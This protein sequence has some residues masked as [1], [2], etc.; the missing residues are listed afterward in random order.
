MTEYTYNGN[1][2]IETSENVYQLINAPIS[3]KIGGFLRTL[4]Y[5]WIFS[6]IPLGIYHGLDYYLDFEVSWLRYAQFVI[7]ALV[8]WV[9]IGGLF[10][11]KITRCPYCDGEMGRNTNINLTNRDKEVIQCER[12]YE[13]LIIDDGTMRAFT[14]DDAQPNQQFEAPVFENSVWP[15]ECIACGDPVTHYEEL[16]AER[17]NGELLVLGL[18]ST[19]SGSISNIPY[20]DKHNKVVSL[21]IKSDG[22]L[23]VSFPDFEMFKRF[24]TIN[25]VRKI[26]II[27]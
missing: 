13:Q 2:K 18:A 17:F 11:D 4:L 27:K 20:C 12:C 19:S 8:L 16:K 15:S 1:I 26:I 3:V 6:L 14:K 23:W 9:G 5:G 21:K 22:K 24:L 10:K 25:T 7:M